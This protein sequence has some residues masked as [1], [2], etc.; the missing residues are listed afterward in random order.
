[1]KLNDPSLLIER[2][3]VGGAWTGEPATPVTNPGQ[4]HEGER[5]EEEDRQE[6]GSKEV[7]C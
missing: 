1:M 3:F 7:Q 2:C 4:N 6:G 5:L